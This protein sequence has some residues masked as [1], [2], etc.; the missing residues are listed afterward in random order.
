MVTTYQTAAGRRGSD[1]AFRD[2]NTLFTVS[3]LQGDR[4]ASGSQPSSARYKLAERRHP[5]RPRAA[6]GHA[7]DRARRGDQPY[8]G[9]GKPVGL[10]ENANAF[11]D[12]LV[13]ERNAGD[14]NRLD[15]LIPPD[16]VN[17]LRVMAATIS[18][19]LQES[20]DE[21]AEEA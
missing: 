11:K 3:F 13:V 12:A 6:G 10:V 16:L 8:S 4:S 19:T 21:A 17:Q 2:A 7:V 9:C 1:T 14:P 15:F 20:L 18:F 5:V